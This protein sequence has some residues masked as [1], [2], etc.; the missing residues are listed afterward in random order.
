M[1][2]QYRA[3][4]RW[5]YRA[6]PRT[7]RSLLP[8]LLTVV[9][10]LPAAPALAG[11]SPGAAMA[12]DASNAVLPSARDNLGFG[13]FATGVVAAT[14]SCTTANGSAA[15][16]GCD[17]TAGLAVGQLLD[18]PGIA[19]GTTVAGGITATGFTMNAN[20]GA[21]AGAGLVS[22]RGSFWSDIDGGTPIIWRLDGRLMVG[23]AVG[24]FATR[25]TSQHGDNFCPTGTYCA[26]WLPRDAQF[27]SMSTRGG[28]AVVGMT[29][30]S[31]GNDL[32]Q[33]APIGVA[34][35]LINDSTLPCC[36]IGWAGYFDVQHE[37]GADASYGIEVAVKNKS[38]NYTNYPYGSGVGATIGLQ[39]TAGGDPTYG[40]SPT[41]PSA[42]AL[43]IG[44]NSD[45]WNTGILFQSD[46]LTGDTGTS[47]V[48][49]AIDMGEGML[50]D[51]RASDNTQGAYIYSTDSDGNNHGV[52]QVFANDTISFN[53]NGHAT[54]LQA[55]HTA[56]AV[57]YSQ[58]AN[59]ATGVA[60]KWSCTGA[61]TNVSCEIAPKGAGV[62]Q[63]DGPLLS[64]TMVAAK[65]ANYNIA[66]T[67]S[68]TT[69]DN[70]G[71]A[72][73]V[74]LS[75]P[76]ISIGRR[77]CFIVQAAQTLKIIAA[78]GNHIAIGTSV[79]ASG[80]NIASAAPDSS[81]C[82]T[83]LSGSW[84]STGHEGTWTVN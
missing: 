58:I 33:S 84:I 23:N 67:D 2:T 78:G 17:S 80:G 53:G 69:F 19:A 46:A 5:T 65:T 76:P 52:S 40:G 27:L 3:A 55:V 51:W 41:N 70:F 72:G 63:V 26:D 49:V 71:A 34:G 13:G 16:T 28:F 82:L 57:N 77:Y 8:A 74:D 79:S 10:A 37:A 44:K 30:A 22:A 54:I 24:T 36:D 42:T 75:L 4:E 56:S 12:T 66:T 39:L 61:D 62:V 45:T 31:D 50:I 14:M 1:L 25:N 60:P 81:I 64:P 15:V 35:A 18:G 47:G 7:R 68:G 9:F 48:G 32:N 73:E 21:G 20:A 83:A 29:R 38:N 6:N 59:G 43:V 11:A